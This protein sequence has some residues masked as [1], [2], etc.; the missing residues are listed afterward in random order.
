MVVGSSSEEL[1]KRSRD[2]ELAEYMD[3][4]QKSLTALLW[5]K[6]FAQSV[7]K[8]DAAEAGG[9]RMSAQPNTSEATG[10][11]ALPAAVAFG[12]VFLGAWNYESVG[13]RGCWTTVI[14]CGTLMLSVRSRDS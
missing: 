13:I 12:R 11:C 14:K 7:L 5:Y 6:R 8:V 10:F 4:T 2:A 1:L 3:L 9:N